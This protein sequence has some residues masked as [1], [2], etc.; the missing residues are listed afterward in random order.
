MP[1]T[2]EYPWRVYVSRSVPGDGPQAVPRIVR[3]YP[4]KPTKPGSRTH[5]DSYGCPPGRLALVPEQYLTLLVVVDD[6]TKQGSPSL[7]ESLAVL[8]SVVD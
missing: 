7:R 8:T 6:A 4:T 3:G 1:K 2:G 5:R